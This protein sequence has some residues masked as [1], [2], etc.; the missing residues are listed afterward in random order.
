MDAMFKDFRDKHYGQMAPMQRYE[1][2]ELIRD[3]IANLEGLA[4]RKLKTIPAG[5]ILHW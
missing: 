3:A 5:E 2:E 4:K 1:Y